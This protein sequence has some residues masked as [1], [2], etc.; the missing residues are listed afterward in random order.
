MAWSGVPWPVLP[1]RKPGPAPWPATAGL[2]LVCLAVL[3]VAPSGA[4]ETR[5]FAGE[6]LSPGEWSRL[7]GPAQAALFRQCVKD[8]ASATL[9]PE[10]IDL[11]LLR[12]QVL[13]HTAAHRLRIVAWVP[14][15]RMETVRILVPYLVRNL[16]NAGGVVDSVLLFRNNPWDHAA[17]RYAEELCRRHAEFAV[18]DPPDFHVRRFGQRET[19]WALNWAWMRLNATD[20]LY[21][22]VDDDIVFIEDGAFEA[23]VQVKLANPRYL[24][25]SANVVNSYYSPFMHA[26][27]GAWQPPSPQTYWGPH[28]KDNRTFFGQH[29]AFLAQAASGPRGLRPYRFPGTWNFSACRCAQP[30]HGFTEPDDCTGGYIRWGI[31]FCIFAGRD[32][33]PIK[34]VKMGKRMDKPR[35]PYEEGHVTTVRPHREGRPEGL[36]GAAVVDHLA[37]TSQRINMT[38]P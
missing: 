7:D 37:Y 4:S 29:H 13:G 21:V 5:R 16:R 18:V 17:H 11:R 22:R 23:L 32:G 26:Y 10:P 25:V 38:R 20:A 33:Q 9:R 27:T 35:P 24:L 19:L 6:D 3:A 31:N 14:W 34:A 30:A 36:A 12:R 8:Q 28:F 15:G 2:L 1:C